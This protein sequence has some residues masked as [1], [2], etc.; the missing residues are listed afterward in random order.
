[1]A[2]CIPAPSNIHLATS[3]HKY[4][5][6]PLASSTSS[7]YSDSTST[8]SI[9]DS[10]SSSGSVVSGSSP[11]S[12]VSVSNDVIVEAFKTRW[13]GFLR[14]ERPRLKLLC[15]GPN[16][17]TKAQDFII[18]PHEHYYTLHKFLA[19]LN[20]PIQMQSPGTKLPQSAARAR[21]TNAPALVWP[22]AVAE[23]CDALIEKSG[24]LL[25]PRFVEDIEQ[26]SYKRCVEFDDMNET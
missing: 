9:G 8:S 7:Q 2:A 14:N 4:L 19:D 11:V 22:S 6:E 18:V 13:R 25:P 24:N 10:S 20:S 21:S 23:T 26:E 12:R 5:K 1:M 15:L 16:V 3:H 17:V